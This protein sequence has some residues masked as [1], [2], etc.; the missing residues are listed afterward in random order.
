M[1]AISGSHKPEVSNRNSDAVL[2]RRS[3]GRFGSEVPSALA[4]DG[5]QRSE[6]L[7]GTGMF[8]IDPYP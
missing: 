7:L 6:D 8:S 2:E 3:A 5:G 1:K 4:A